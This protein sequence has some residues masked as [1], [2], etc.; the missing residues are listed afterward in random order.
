MALY[1]KKEEE[2]FEEHPEIVLIDWPAKSPDLNPIENLWSIITNKWDDEDNLN[3][4]NVN[5][6]REHTHNKWNDIQ[7]DI[8]NRLERSM[9]KRL[10]D[11]ISNGGYHT[12]Y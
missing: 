10:M 5:I 6:L 7:N 2:W 11:V 1:I 8:C 3:L 4:R 12:K 9:Q